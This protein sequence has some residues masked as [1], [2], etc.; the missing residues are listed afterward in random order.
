LYNNNS[1]K[2][3]DRIKANADKTCRQ[4]NSSIQ[5]DSNAYCTA[6]TSQWVDN[7]LY[8]IG[9]H[10]YEQGVLQVNEM[11]DPVH[12]NW[13]TKAPMPTPREHLSI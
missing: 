7:Q 8:V 11:Y 1:I 10:N 9:G 2:T 12:N 6:L 5:I 3:M 13:T 4:V